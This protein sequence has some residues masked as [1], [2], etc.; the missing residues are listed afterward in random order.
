[1][2]VEPDSDQVTLQLI[3]GDQPMDYDFE[4]V[5]NG[6]VAYGDYYYVR[7]KQL[8]GAMAWSSPIWVGGEEPR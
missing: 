1:M 4:F 2:P 5:D 7:V 8:N 3:S 6:D